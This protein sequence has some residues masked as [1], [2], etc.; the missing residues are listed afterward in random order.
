MSGPP[1]NKLPRGSNPREQPPSPI[2]YRPPSPWTAASPPPIISGPPGPRG[3]SL[4]SPG[5]RPF[6]PIP[7]NLNRSNQNSPMF[8]ASGLRGTRGSGL[9]APRPQWPAG[10]QPYNGSQGY[11]TPEP[12][13]PQPPSYSPHLYQPPTPTQQHHQNHDAHHQNNQQFQYQPPVTPQPYKPRTLPTPPPSSHGRTTPSYGTTTKITPNNTSPAP[14][15]P[16]SAMISPMEYMRRSSVDYPQYEYAGPPNP[17]SYVIYDDE[18]E[19]GPSTREIIAN[20]SQD[21]IDEKLAEYQATIF[22]LQGELPSFFL[23]Y[24]KY[25]N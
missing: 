10:P 17:K 8:G 22:Q 4:N 25:C 7:G 9:P 2:Y 21:Y 16:T 11:Q 12:Y 6:S 14:Y 1:P 18:D 24:I 5:I 19:G 23:K 20:Q 15:V 13:T 3:P